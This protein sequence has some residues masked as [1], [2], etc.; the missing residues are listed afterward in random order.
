MPPTTAEMAPG[1][2]ARGLDALRDALKSNTTE[3]NNL[4]AEVRKNPDWEDLRRSETALVA[5]IKA[6]AALRKAE[7]ITAD[8]AIKSLQDWNKW[9]V[10]TVGGL[11]LAAVIASALSAGIPGG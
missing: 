10:R 2:V 4:A 9:A 8:L 3:L 7:R 1:E 5:Q 11:V 6:E